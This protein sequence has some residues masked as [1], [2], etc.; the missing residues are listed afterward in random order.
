MD[1]I[2]AIVEYKEKEIVMLKSLALQPYSEGMLQLLN[3]KEKQLKHFVTLPGYL[4]MYM[5]D[6]IEG[7][8][9]IMNYLKSKGDKVSISI[10]SHYNGNQNDEVVLG[11]D[12]IGEIT[13][14]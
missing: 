12:V 5:Q 13:K 8:D 14:K 7:M 9:Y 11:N 3:Q 4:S 1:K 6:N 2:K 10:V